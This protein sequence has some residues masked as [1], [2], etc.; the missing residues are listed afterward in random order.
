[1]RWDYYW[2]IWDNISKKVLD[3]IYFTA[4]TSD[5]FAVCLFQR[6]VRLTLVQTSMNTL[7]D[8]WVNAELPDVCVDVAQRYGCAS[9]LP[10][11]NAV[12]DAAGGVRDFADGRR[13]SREEI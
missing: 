1:M 13:R 10:R 12:Q 2:Q 11:A 5:D 3:D 8:A 6:V 9:E 4:A 7:L